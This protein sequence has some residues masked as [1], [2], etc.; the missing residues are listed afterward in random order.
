MVVCGKGRIATRALAHTLHYAKA[1]ALPFTILAS[2]N[3]DDS[4][5]DTW[6]PSLLR[7]A[8]TLDIPCVAL[9]DVEE[10]P[11]LLLISLEYDRLIH[12]PRFASERLYNI[13]FSALP[14]YRG[15]YTSIWPILNGET[16]VGVTLH[17][18]DSRIDTGRIVAQAAAPLPPHMDARGLY[19]LYMDMGLSLYQSW[20][21]RLVLSIPPGTPQDECLATSYDRRSVDV[22]CVEVDLAND[23]VRVCAFVRAFAF[24]EYQLPTVAGRRVRSCAAVPGTTDLAPGTTIH[25]TEFST[26]FAV[27]DRGIVEMVWA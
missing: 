21:P 10:I 14:R 13:H 16:S 9:Q 2:P 19:D 11:D 18:M 5:L 17:Y 8:K 3:R 6:Q 26:S 15:V 25:D 24:P 23:P 27:G 12:V 20:L 7:T 4:G 1:N 22:R